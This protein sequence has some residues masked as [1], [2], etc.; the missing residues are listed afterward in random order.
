MSNATYPMSSFPDDA[1]PLLIDLG[2]NEAH[3]R[4][5]D[6]H[7]VK[8]DGVLEAYVPKDHHKRQRFVVKFANPTQRKELMPRR[9]D[10]T[11]PNWK[12]SFWVWYTAATFIQQEERLKAEQEVHAKET[13]R[14]AAMQYVESKANGRVTIEQLKRVFDL[15]FITNTGEFTAVKTQGYVTL[16]FRAFENLTPDEQLEKAI[17]V[18]SML[19]QE[20]MIRK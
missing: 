12:K 20:G 11:K 9:I 10:T 16:S 14:K 18:V 4:Y 5:N 17:R 13:A 3:F 1:I 8:A 15:H 6:Q 2:F 7:V 19:I